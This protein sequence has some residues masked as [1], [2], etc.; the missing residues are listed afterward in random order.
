MTPYLKQK[1]IDMKE[2]WFSQ[3]CW[4]KRFPNEYLD[5]LEEWEKGLVASEPIKKGELV[6]SFGGDDEIVEG[7][8]FIRNSVEPNCQ[9]IGRDVFANVDIPTDK[10]ITLY[11]HGIL[12]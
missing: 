6:A 4:V 1:A 2:R 11:Y 12:L 10:E 7:K 9:L 3:K 8:H 5:D